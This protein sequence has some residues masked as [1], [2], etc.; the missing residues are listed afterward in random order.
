MEREKKECILA[1]ACRAFARFGFKKASVEDIAREAG[2]AK[3]T[4]YL[5]YPS[6]QAIYDALFHEGMV[7]LEAR[8]QERLASARGLKDAIAVFVDV[9][10]RY[11]QEFPDYYRIYV[12]EVGR[13][14]SDHA[15]K[16]NPCKS[17]IDSQGRM[18]QKRFEQ[19]V[20][21]GEIRPIDPAAASMAVFDITRGLVGRRLLTGETS[22]AAADIAF[23]ID[24]IWTGL[25]K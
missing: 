16:K 11:F 12:A 5:Y 14:L 13:Q 23:I 7:E 10:V 17:A 6:K 19:A 9:K 24:L 21:A 1:A 2:V 15:P 18:L 3:G 25:A 22:D 20:S 8:V 4:V